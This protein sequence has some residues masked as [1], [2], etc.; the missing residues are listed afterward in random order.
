MQKENKE[1]QEEDNTEFSSLRKDAIQG[2][3]WCIGAFR[4][5]DVRGILKEH[6][7]VRKE[8]RKH[9]LHQEKRF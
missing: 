3:A 5:F 2:N 8:E 6:K 9:A 7:K 1:N 4:F